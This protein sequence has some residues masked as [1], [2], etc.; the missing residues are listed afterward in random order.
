MKS[1]GGVILFEDTTNKSQ[2]IWLYLLV[3]LNWVFTDN[4]HNLG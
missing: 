3:L 2:V 1:K 4:K